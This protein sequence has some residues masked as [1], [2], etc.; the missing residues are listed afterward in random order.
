[1]LEPQ[2]HTATVIE[3]G[4]S[5]HRERYLRWISEALVEKG[6]VVSIALASNHGICERFLQW[7]TE[8]H[9]SI[10]YLDLPLP[11]KN[12]V[13]LQGLLLYRRIRG[14][15]PQF[16]RAHNLVFFPS[17]DAIAYFVT[18]FGLPCGSGKCA[19]IVM[20]PYFHIERRRNWRQVILDKV[21]KRLFN[22][23]MKSKLFVRL[24][25]IDELLFELH[26]AKTDGKLIYLADPAYLATASNRELPELS[27][28]NVLIYGSIDERKGVVEALGAL[29]YIHEKK[30]S[31][32]T[33][34]KFIVAGRTSSYMEQLLSSYSLRYPDNIQVIN[35]HIS[36]SEEC[37]LFMSASIVWV[38]YSN[39]FNMSGV[40]A[41][42]GLAGKPVIG[43]LEGLISFLIKRYELGE[44]AD[45]NYSKDISR[46]LKCLLGDPVRSEKMGRNGRAKFAKHTVEN[47]KQTIGDAIDDYYF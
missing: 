7:G 24:F 45:T 30:E 2:P 16:T 19:G 4:L 15:I 21:K 9:I 32:L 31:Q 14:L 36:D 10:D 20:R 28:T 41:Q 26:G 6:Y 3:I 29:D 27:G 25:T 44:I 38:A 8:H 39:F 17:L 22:R 5:G 11:E 43:N 35:R 47:F 37:D 33:P 12:S 13:F 46:A 18:L 34:L 40:L 23:L 1:M 42:A